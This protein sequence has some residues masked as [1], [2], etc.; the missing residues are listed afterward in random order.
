MLLADP[1]GITD[2]VT[3]QATT[4]G[5]GVPVKNPG[6]VLTIPIPGITLT[7]PDTGTTLTLPATRTELT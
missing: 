7:I 5:D 6:T 4:L 1:V 3:K 2:V